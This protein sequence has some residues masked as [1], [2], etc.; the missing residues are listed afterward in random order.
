MLGIS[1]NNKKDKD[2]K[3]MNDLRSHITKFECNYDAPNK[4]WGRIKS[5]HSNAF[6]A[7]PSIEDSF[8]VCMEMENMPGALFGMF[9][10][11]SGGLAS[12]F[13]RDNLFNFIFDDYENRKKK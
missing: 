1:S 5:Y 6:K 10:G 4:K 2:A 3:R 11:H 13:C 7:N 8:A 9:D 12:M